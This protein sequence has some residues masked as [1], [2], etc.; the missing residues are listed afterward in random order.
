MK[1]G[2]KVSCV[3]PTGRLKKGQEYIIQE[4]VIMPC[5]CTVFHVGHYNN[6]LRTVE[7]I[8]HYGSK[9]APDIIRWYGSH[10]FAPL[11]YNSAHDKILSEIADNP[12]ERIDVPEKEVV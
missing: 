8:K 4:A 6:E 1:V 9:M 5:G 7:C 2:D 3:D 10:R 12:T 11:Q